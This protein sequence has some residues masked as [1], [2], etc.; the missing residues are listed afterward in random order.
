M[1]LLWYAVI[2]IGLVPLLLVLFKKTDED[3]QQPGN[4]QNG[5]NN[6]TSNNTTVSRRG[7]LSLSGNKVCLNAKAFLQEDE[8]F[9]NRNDQ[10]ESGEINDEFNNDERIKSLKDLTK[11]NDVYL[12]CQVSSDEEQNYYKDLLETRYGFFNQVKTLFC[13]TSKGKIA[14][15]RQINPQLC[16]EVDR[17]TTR[18]LIRFYQNVYMIKKQAKNGLNEDKVLEFSTI[19]DALTNASKRK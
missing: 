18:E 12:I 4:T 6:N 5:T 14:F 7:D 1:N 15:C 13:E 8:L 11:S 17:E 16:F 2:I 9:E 3:Q 10:K 19:T